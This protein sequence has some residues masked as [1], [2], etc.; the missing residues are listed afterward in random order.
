MKRWIC[1]VLLS[2]AL[3]GCATPVVIDDG[4][5]TRT[6]NPC[7]TDALC[8]RDSY[9][10]VWDNWCFNTQRDYPV[11]YRTKQYEYLSDRTEYILSPSANVEMSGGD[12]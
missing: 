2:C 4:T 1:F 5:R 10:L 6:F 9:S 7:T 12:L 8:F 11:T 3:T